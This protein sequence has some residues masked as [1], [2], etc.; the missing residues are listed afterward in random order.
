VVIQGREHTCHQELVNHRWRRASWMRVETHCQTR[1]KAV[2]VGF[3]MDWS[4]TY[5][6]RMI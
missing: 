2:A 6:P 5:L 4:L 3:L 1:L